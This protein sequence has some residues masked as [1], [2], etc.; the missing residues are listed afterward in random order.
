MARVLHLV[1]ATDP[2]LAADVIRR[3]VAAGDDV[4]VVLL[5]GAAAPDLPDGVRTRRVPDDL[6]YDQL[7]EDIFA[8]DRVVTW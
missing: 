5:A 8:A 1:P 7:L 3:D 4:A 2:G 6:S